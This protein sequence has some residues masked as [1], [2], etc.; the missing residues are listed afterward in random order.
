MRTRTIVRG[1]TA[2]G[3]LLGL[4]LGAAALDVRQ[5]AGERQILV[6]VADQNKVPITGLTAADFAIR[7]D[8]VDREIVRAA[9]ATDP[10]YI[11]L[12]TDT[13]KGAPG[14]PERDVRDLRNALVAFVKQVHAAS[15]ETMIAL[16]DHGGAAVKINDFTTDT[17]ALEKK[18]QRIFFKPDPSVALEAM[19]EA[20]RE[21]KNKKS[22]RKFIICYQLDNAPE[23]SQVRGSDIARN[24][25][26]VYPQ[27]WAVTLRD[28][29]NSNPTRDNI[30]NGLSAMTGG[31]RLTVLTSSTLEVTFKQ[32]ADLLMGQYAVTFMRPAMPK[33]PQK[34]E[35]RVN[36]ENV[37]VAAPAWPPK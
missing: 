13:S 28:R 32:I 31:A 1:V 29:N 18:I 10:A 12:T 30:L 8:G 19:D 14:D 9:P 4:G 17:A 25:Q 24:I 11:V 37:L 15:P 3:V 21:L 36:R 33:P 35:I 16:M 26:Q 27:V 22:T 2:A 23:H 6:T 34:L 7:E 20:A 5:G